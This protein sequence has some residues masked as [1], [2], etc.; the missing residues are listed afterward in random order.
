MS[1]ARRWWQSRR[2]SG[3]SKLGGRRQRRPRRNG[4]QRRKVLWI[5][6]A[7]TWC[8][9]VERTLAVA[10]SAGDGEQGG[11]DEEHPWTARLGRR[12]LNKRARICSSLSCTPAPKITGDRSMRWSRPSR[13]RQRIQTRGLRRRRWKRAR[14]RPAGTAQLC[15]SPAYGQTLGSKLTGQDPKRSVRRLRGRRPSHPSGGWAKA[16]GGWS[17]RSCGGICRRKA[18]AHAFHRVLVDNS[19]SCRQWQEASVPRR[20]RSP[21]RRTQ[22]VAHEPAPIS[23]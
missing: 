12:T 18:G 19:A 13:T 21:D 15:R 23:P 2:T 22:R 1:D 16:V 6:E 5:L 8:V 14:T 4:T 10:R 7:A 3:G 9:V 17:R 20:N 11:G